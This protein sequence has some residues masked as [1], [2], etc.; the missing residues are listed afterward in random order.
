MPPPFPPVQL[1]PQ[2]P[3]IPAALLLMVL[4]SITS[5]ELALLEIPPPDPPSRLEAPLWLSLIVLFRIVR[6][7]GLELSPPFAM[8][9]P[10]PPRSPS[11]VPEPVL[12]LATVLFDSVSDPR[13]AMPPPNPP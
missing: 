13:F 10:K 6:L 7:P 3:P 12:L 2:P 1:D 9:P 8:P 4:F 11:L 5:D